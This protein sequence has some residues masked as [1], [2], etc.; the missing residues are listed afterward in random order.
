MFKRLFWLMVGAGFGF[1]VSFWLMR[2]VRET[3]ARYAPERVSADLTSA[4]KGLGEDL[5]AAVAEGR[6][7]MRERE[8]ELRADAA[9]R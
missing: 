9:P 8:A 7:A 6:Q 4:L 5:R 3:A 2:F 1:G